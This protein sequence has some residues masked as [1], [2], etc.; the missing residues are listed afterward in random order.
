MLA[1]FD[2]D[3]LDASNQYVFHR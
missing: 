1:S 2:T 3:V